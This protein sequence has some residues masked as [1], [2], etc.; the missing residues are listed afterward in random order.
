MVFFKK[1]KKKKKKKKISFLTQ[2]A[3]NNHLLNW[4]I[5]FLFDRRIT[6][7]SWIMR[8]IGFYPSII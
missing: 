3:R 1:K 6:N 2:K 5:K 7:L 4:M 8:N